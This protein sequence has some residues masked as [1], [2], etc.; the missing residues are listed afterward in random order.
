MS[1]LEVDSSVFLILVKI[2]YILFLV[3]LLSSINF[4]QFHSQILLQENFPTV[5]YL[6]YTHAYRSYWE[7]AEVARHNRNGLYAA[8]RLLK[9]WHL[10]WK[11]SWVLGFL[12]TRNSEK[13]YSVAQA[14]FTSLNFFPWCSAFQCMFGNY[15]TYSLYFYY[16]KFILSWDLHCI[17]F[18]YF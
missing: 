2:T 9:L 1:H 6:I 14:A 16:P 15:F 18:E 11:N 7:R 4:S 3:T 13:H 12:H 17:S 10:W 5:N 8:R